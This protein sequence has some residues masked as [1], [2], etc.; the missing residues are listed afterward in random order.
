MKVDFQIAAP[1]GVNFLPPQPPYYADKVRSKRYV[2]ICCLILIWLGRCHNWI[3]QADDQIATLSIGQIDKSILAARDKVRSGHVV[4]T[5]VKQTWN[6]KASTWNEVRHR[7]ECYFDGTSV[8]TDTVMRSTI[9]GDGK[10]DDVTQIVSQHKSMWYMWIRPLSGAGKTSTALTVID[11]S[12]LVTADYDH[13]GAYADLDKA[14]YD[15]RRLGLALSADTSLHM[16]GKTPL[17]FAM[18]RRNVEIKQDKHQGENCLEVSFSYD[19]AQGVHTCR[20]WIVPNWDWAVVRAETESTQHRTVLDY[21]YKRH[22]PS[23]SWFPTKATSQRYW[24]GTCD[25]KEETVLDVKSLNQE[26][27][28]DVFMPQGFGVP[29]GC[30]VL[31]LPDSNRPSTMHYQW[32]GQEIVL[33]SNDLIATK[34][35]DSNDT[36]RGK[37]WSAGRIIGVALAIIGTGMIFF[38]ARRFVPSMPRRA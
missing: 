29:A 38:V 34:S 36:D 11:R 6:A 28:P 13:L 23:G 5:S 31:K 24:K 8:R 21:Q 37:F 19:T 20:L 14:M 1:I 22:T 3:V 17:V 18:N 16:T 35:S 2:W 15:P 32:N 4:V 26:L 9:R 27:S 25:Y 12:K 30:L 7:H 33:V 10:E